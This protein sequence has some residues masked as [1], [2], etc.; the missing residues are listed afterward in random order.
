MVSD[1]EIGGRVKEAFSKSDAFATQSALAAAVDMAPDALSRALNGTRAFSSIEITRIAEVVG[2]DVHWLITGEPDPLAIRFVARHDYDTASRRYGL[3]DGHQESPALEGIA[4][5]YQQAAPWMTERVSELPSTPAEM[6]SVLGE[7]F[8]RDFADRI[9]SC[10]GVD[11]V[12]LQGPV[13]DYSFTVSG[14]AVILLKSTPNWF[15]SNWSLGHELAHLALDHSAADAT[16]KSDEQTANAFAA[17]LL[18]PRSEMRAQ[19]WSAL[20]EESLAVL[21]WQYGVSLEALANRLNALHVRAPIVDSAKSLGSTQRLLGSHQEAL[22]EA[23]SPD[24][25]SERMRQA[26]ERRIPVLLI[27]AHRRGIADG[28]L[29]KGTLAWLLETT[30]DELEVEEP[31]QR[32]PLSTD[33]LMRALG[34]D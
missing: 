31:P 8:V 19:Q 17:E 32:E 21:L 15:R 9:D 12:R 30:P 20:D 22:P 27:E 23:V 1:Q 11:V 25:I 4:L 14:Q 5:A 2:E 29:S 28:R 18:M 33:A 16:S 24:P 10:L 34:A 13:T 3:P 7:G 6:R 26:S